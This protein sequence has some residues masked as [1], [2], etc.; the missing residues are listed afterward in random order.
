MPAQEMI[1]QRLEVPV[2]V[3]KPAQSERV[4][5]AVGVFFI[6]ISALGEGEDIVPKP[7]FKGAR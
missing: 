1:T 7:L 2:A 4:L 6:D 3:L 5:G